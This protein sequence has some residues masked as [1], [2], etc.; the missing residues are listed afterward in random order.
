[1]YMYLIEEPFGENVVCDTLDDVYEYIYRRLIA[2][3]YDVEDVIFNDLE[4]DFQD[5]KDLYTDVDT[6][7]GIADFFWCSAVKKFDRN[8]IPMRF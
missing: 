2:K 1:M 3:G 8:E 7:I 6:P 4:R 5:F